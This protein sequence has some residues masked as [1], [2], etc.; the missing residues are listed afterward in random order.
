MKTY[1]LVSIIIIL[2]V[3]NIYQFKIDTH[4]SALLVNEEQL[5]CL[6]NWRPPIDTID[7]FGPQPL[8]GLKIAFVDTQKYTEG[9]YVG[10]SGCF[11][12][13]TS[14]SIDVDDIPRTYRLMTSRGV[15]QI[16]FYKHS[17]S[18]NLIMYGNSD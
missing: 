2:S 4:S 14:Q 15:K 7:V 9:F 3:L 6:Q 1:I 5:K 8:Q 11:F 13:T 12:N 16:Y 10:F 18:D 17:S